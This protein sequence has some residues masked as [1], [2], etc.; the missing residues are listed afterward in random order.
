M[1]HFGI[2]DQ[3]GLNNDPIELGYSIG[4]PGSKDRARSESGLVV[5]EREV[6]M[7]EAWSRRR[8][9]AFHLLEPL[10]GA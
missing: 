8:S 10:F 3:N 9:R 2:T 6:R 1:I 5:G 4:R 7:G